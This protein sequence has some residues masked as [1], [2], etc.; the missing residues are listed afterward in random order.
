MFRV[1]RER[2]YEDAFGASAPRTASTQTAFTERTERSGKKTDRI[3]GKC[4]SMA[5]SR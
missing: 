2:F 3:K 4:A 1:P 5:R